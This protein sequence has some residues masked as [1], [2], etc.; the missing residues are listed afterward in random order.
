[1]GGSRVEWVESIGMM[2]ESEQI[3]A[4]LRQASGVPG[5]FLQ[6]DKIRNSWVWINGAAVSRGEKGFACD[7]LV[8]SSL[9]QLVLCFCILATEYWDGKRHHRFLTPTIS[10]HDEAGGRS[11]SLYS[12]AFL[13]EV[14]TIILQY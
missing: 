2:F 1:M 11:G 5:F 12:E 8:G 4:R 13:S 6:G 7:R 14:R 10:H 3:A 9:C